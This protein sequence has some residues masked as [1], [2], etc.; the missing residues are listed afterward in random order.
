LLTLGV[1]LPTCEYNA[2]YPGCVETESKALPLR[3]MDTAVAK[4]Q[5]LSGGKWAKGEDGQDTRDEKL[6][7]R[8][9]VYSAAKVLEVYRGVCL[10]KTIEVRQ[11]ESRHQA[12]FHQMRHK[13]ASVSFGLRGRMGQPVQGSSGTYIVS[14]VLDPEGFFFVDQ[15]AIP[16]PVE[17]IE[18]LRETDQDLNTFLMQKVECLAVDDLKK[19]AFPG[20]LLNA[21]NQPIE[22]DFAPPAKD[23]GF[24][25]RKYNQTELD[26]IRLEAVLTQPDARKTMQDPIDGVEKTCFFKGERPISGK[27]TVPCKAIAEGFELSEEM[28]KRKRPVS[29]RFIVAPF[30]T[31]CT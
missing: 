22:I 28:C 25:G 20:S 8:T 24:E 31:K 21:P 4:I 10:P 30:P 23:N 5:I 11:L 3:A 26:R 29:E 2:D 14:G 12:C 16:R 15:C 17:A 9:M 18:T 13:R 1:A 27:E 19:L 7:R 6:Q